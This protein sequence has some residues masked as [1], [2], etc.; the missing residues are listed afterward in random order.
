M[1]VLNRDAINP[2]RAGKVSKQ[3]LTGT[4]HGLASR[5][6]INRITCLCC[7]NRLRL[8]DGGPELQ[9]CNGEALD[10]EREYPLSVGAPGTLLVDSGGRAAL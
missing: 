3:A 9:A 4:S 8:H 6:R 1:A 2:E 5:L 7:C 10:M